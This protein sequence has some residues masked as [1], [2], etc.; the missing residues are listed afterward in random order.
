MFSDPTSV[1][2]ISTV[3]SEILIAVGL[4]F[5]LISDVSNKEKS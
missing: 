4:G 5:Y 1:H 3:I 2:F